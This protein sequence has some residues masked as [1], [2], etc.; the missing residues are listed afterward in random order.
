MNRIKQIMIGIIS[1]VVILISS[2]YIFNEKK[3]NNYMKT[4]NNLIYMASMDTSQDTTY[5]EQALQYIN[6]IVYAEY[7]AKAKAYA[8]YAGS[9]YLSSRN[10]Y[11]EAMRLIERVPEKNYHPYEKRVFLKELEIYQALNVKHD[12]II[13]KKL[14]SELGDSLSSYIRKTNGNNIYLIDALFKWKILSE[15]L[16][17]AYCIARAYPEYFGTDST[18]WKSFNNWNNMHDNY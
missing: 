8:A 6:K 16:D 17:S 10:R 13:A 14:A 2:Y 4:A 5:S 18:E 7:N 3:Y 1:I 9:V 15:G 12:T 11:V